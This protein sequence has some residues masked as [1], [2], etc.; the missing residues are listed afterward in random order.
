L[1]N[2]GFDDSLKIKFKNKFLLVEIQNFLLIIYFLVSNHNE[3]YFYHV[4]YIKLPESFNI[5]KNTTENTLQVTNEN[6][7]NINADKNID[8]DETEDNDK[9]TELVADSNKIIQSKAYYKRMEKSRCIC[10]I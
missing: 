3:H 2:L 10:F 9:V 4:F 1:K 7:N 8:Y 5:I 6:N